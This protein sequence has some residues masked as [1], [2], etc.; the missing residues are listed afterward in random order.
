MYRRVFRVQD[1]EGRGPFRPGFSSMWMD[2]DRD[3]YP[4]TFIEEFGVDIFDKFGRP[5]EHF[6]SAVR[7]LDGLDRWFSP[8]ERKRLRDFGYRI[9]VIHD[10]RVIADSENQCVIARARPLAENVSLRNL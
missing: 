2:P 8:T 9:A 3:T 5:G 7:T 1:S 10:A 6:G 4:P